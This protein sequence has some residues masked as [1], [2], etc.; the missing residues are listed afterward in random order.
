[1]NAF[2]EKPFTEEMLLTTIQTVLR[3]NPAPVAQEE[4]N[5][6]PET[7]TSGK[8]NLQNLFHLAGGDTDFARQMLITFLETTTKGLEEMKNAASAGEWQEVADLAH[9]LMP[10]GRHIGADRLADILRK[11]EHGIGNNGEPSVAAGDLKEAEKEFS[12]VRDLI[13]EEISKIS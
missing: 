4:N 1:M 11:I 9:K 3:D 12:E 13:N 6:S 7:G 2:L 8:I 10:P 5:D